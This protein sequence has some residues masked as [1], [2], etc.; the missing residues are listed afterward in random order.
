MRSHEALR[1][2]WCVSPGCF[3]TAALNWRVV[4]REAGSSPCDWALFTYWCVCICS[5]RASQPLLQSVFVNWPD[6]CF[7]GVRI[8][9]WS[10]VARSQSSA[11]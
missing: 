2:I 10:G 4:H 6:Y 9:I 8:G 5:L 1:P 3:A 11:T 7:R